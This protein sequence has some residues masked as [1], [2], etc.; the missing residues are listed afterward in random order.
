MDASVVRT[1]TR[2]IRRV[3]DD[4]HGRAARADSDR[5]RRPSDGFRV[6]DARRFRR[7]VDDAVAGLPE[8]LLTAVR[9]AEI[10]IEEVPPAAL[11]NLDAG[12][13]DVPLA[14]WNGAEHR[15][16][17]RITLFRRPLEVRAGSAGELVDLIRL[18]VGE[19]VA[20]A[21]GLDIDLD[22]WP[23]DEDG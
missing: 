23:G 8:E 10:L 12:D 2:T 15:R 3:G 13:E 1:C 20:D 14:A 9:E 17:A 19:E 11:V 22:D 21:L 5:R 7:L 16:S 4:R 6:R 18:A